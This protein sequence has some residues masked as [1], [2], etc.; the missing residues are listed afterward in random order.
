MADLV[1]VVREEVQRLEVDLRHAGEYQVEDG[2]GEVDLHLVVDLGL[3]E[4]ILEVVDQVVD[5]WERSAVVHREEVHLALDL[6]E[7]DLA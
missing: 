2:L 7:V 3:E 1:E 4:V 6:Q 5:L